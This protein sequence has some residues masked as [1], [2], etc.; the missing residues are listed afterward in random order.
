MSGTLTTEFHI[1]A[2][3]IQKGEHER[4]MLY[5]IGDVENNVLF[6]I[7]AFCRYTVI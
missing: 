3:L 5:V 4:G 6:D 2:E 1:A 7:K